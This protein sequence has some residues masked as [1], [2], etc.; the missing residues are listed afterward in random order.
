MVIQC[1][2]GYIVYIST[3]DFFAMTDEQFD[4]FIKT[5]CFQSSDPYYVNSKKLEF[6]EGVFDEDIPQKD[7]SLNEILNILD[8]ESLDTTDYRKSIIIPFEDLE[9][10]DNLDLNFDDYDSD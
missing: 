6:T 3:E 4:E 10:L 2:Y 7:Y 8:S 9:N 1:G 5:K